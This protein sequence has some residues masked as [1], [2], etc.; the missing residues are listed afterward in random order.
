MEFN[1][2]DIVIF[3]GQL[4]EVDGIEK[5]SNNDFIGIEIIFSKKISKFNGRLSIYDDKIK[6]IFLYKKY[7]GGFPRNPN[8]IFGQLNDENLFTLP[9]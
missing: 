7:I 9:K 3:D 6:D 2:G 5:N 1:L 4:G 8:N